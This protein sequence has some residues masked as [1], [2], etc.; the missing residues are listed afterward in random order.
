MDR[1]ADDLQETKD[2]TA[3]IESKWQAASKLGDAYKLNDA[4]NSLQKEC[5]TVMKSKL[6]LRRTFVDEQKAKDEE[7]VK[8]LREQAD[9]IGTLCFHQGE[10]GSVFLM[11]P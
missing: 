2:T 9:N 6:T 5:D 4:L 3:Q 11:L 8:E 1:Q 7:F 10:K